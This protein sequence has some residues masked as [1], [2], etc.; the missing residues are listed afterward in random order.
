MFIFFLLATWP[1]SVPVL[2][3]STLSAAAMLLDK[4]KIM[5]VREMEADSGILKTRVHH[6]L[7]GILQERKILAQ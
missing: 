5:T 3:Y 4:D 1:F 6:I 2:G 7:T